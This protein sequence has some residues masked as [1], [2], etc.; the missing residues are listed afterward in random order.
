LS[1]PI[2]DIIAARSETTKRNIIRTIKSADIHANPPE[3]HSSIDYPDHIG[4]EARKTLTKTKQLWRFGRIF[5]ELAGNR[6]KTRDYRSAMKRSQ[7]PK[8]QIRGTAKGHRTGWS[9]WAMTGVRYKEWARGWKGLGQ[10]IDLRRRMCDTCCR[11]TEGYC[12]SMYQACPYVSKQDS[13]RFLSRRHRRESDTKHHSRS[14][15]HRA[16]SMRI[17]QIGPT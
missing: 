4:K 13:F 15:F 17:P 2:P 3:N 16:R 6:G 14:T 8:A 5:L 9:G 10:K 12:G 11:R 7:Y 1:G